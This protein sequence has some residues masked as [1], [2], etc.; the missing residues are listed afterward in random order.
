MRRDVWFLLDR[1][2]WP[3]VGFGIGSCMASWKEL[4]SCLKKQYWQIIPMGGV[5]RT[6]NAD[7]RQQ[8]QGF[9]GVGC[10]HP[11]VEC[12]INQLNLL[13]MHYGCPSAL[14]LM[15]R[16]SLEYMILELGLSL[17]PLPQSYSKYS[18]WVTHSWLKTI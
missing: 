9:Y 1:Q 8:D 16:I 10:P 12:L 15:Q 7:L 18:D 6:A 2:M 4:S 14:G 3:G 13:L 17:Q 11:G 5:I